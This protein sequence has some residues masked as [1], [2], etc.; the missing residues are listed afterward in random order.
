MERIYV[1][2]E[3]TFLQRGSEFPSTGR[4]KRGWGADRPTG[5]PAKTLAHSGGQ[6]MGER[7]AVSTGGYIEGGGRGGQR[8]SSCFVGRGFL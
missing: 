7:D 4:R 1:E 8:G 6:N 2:G 5:T 3:M